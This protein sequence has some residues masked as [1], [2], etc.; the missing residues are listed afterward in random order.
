MATQ[1]DER[2]QVFLLIGLILAFLDLILGERRLGFRLWK[3]RFEVP[4][5]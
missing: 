1:Y 3:G 4:P 2:F 5:T